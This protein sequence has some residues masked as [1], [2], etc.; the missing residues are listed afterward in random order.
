MLTNLIPT[1]R[2]EYELRRVS[3]SKAKNL[4]FLIDGRFFSRAM[5]ILKNHYHHDVPKPDT[6]R[7]K[8]IHRSMRA[9]VNEDAPPNKVAK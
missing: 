2:P 6:V 7:T 5:L 1:C 3:P 9:Y 8:A 4:V